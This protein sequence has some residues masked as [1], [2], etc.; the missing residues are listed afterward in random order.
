LANASF[1]FEKEDWPRLVHRAVIFDA[2]GFQPYQDYGPGETSYE[3]GEVE[4]E[5]EELADSSPQEST[6][7]AGQS[8]QVLM[9]SPTPQQR[10]WR[11]P[12]QS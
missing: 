5:L 2:D 12:W 3:P 1:G 4:Y 7:P 9:H 8:P 6:P 11:W 10:T